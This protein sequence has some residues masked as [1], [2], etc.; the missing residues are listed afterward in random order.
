MSSADFVA[1][2]NQTYLTK[3][4]IIS[5]LKPH[6]SFLLN[7]EWTEDQLEQHIP[8]DILRYIAENDI[9]FYI[10]DANKES[11]PWVWATGP[12]WCCRRVLQAG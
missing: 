6:G 11:R 4:D 3:Y 8:G 9:H 5:E 1:C 7:C 12:T 2:H 10:I